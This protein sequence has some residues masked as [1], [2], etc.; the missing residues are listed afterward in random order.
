MVTSLYPVIFPP[1]ACSM[2]CLARHVCCRRCPQLCLVGHSRIL[3]IV[4]RW[5]LS[6][7]WCSQYTHPWWVGWMPQ[8]LV[9]QPSLCMWVPCCVLL[10]LLLLL[11][12]FSCPCE[13]RYLCF[14]CGGA[15]FDFF[16][17]TISVFSGWTSGDAGECWCPCGAMCRMFYWCSCSP[18]FTVGSVCWGFLLDSS[19]LF[20][21]IIVY[22]CYA[23]LE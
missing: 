19:W 9:L 6:S 20:V 3:V 1:V 2:P 12:P 16:F 15:D 18:H 17:D 11:F 14:G 4:P 23:S 21:D 7:L 10:A 13:S 5:L 22:H 8:V